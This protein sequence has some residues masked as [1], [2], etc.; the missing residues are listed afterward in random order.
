M[1]VP[2][3]HNTARRI[4]TAERR[5]RLG[6]RHWLAEPAGD[7]VQAARGILAYH[8][9]DPASVHIAAAVRTGLGGA[10]VDALER[11]LYD[12]RTLV[13]MLGMRRTM[14]V[15]PTELMPVIQ[16]ACADAIAV[17]ERRKTLQIFGEAGIV[18]DIEPW[19]A[20]VEADTLKAL[21]R[22]GA[23]TAA[24]LGADVPWLREQITI[25]K[26]KPYE[27]KLGVSSKVLFL[28]AT[29][30]RLVRGRPN[31]SWI[32]SQYRWAP[33]ETW[34][35]EVVPVPTE[36]ARAELLRHWLAAFG[37]GTVADLKW[38]TGW[39]L[40]DVRKTVAGMEVVDVE[41]DGEPGLVLAE[42][43]DPVDDPDPW[44]ALL[45]ALD[46]TPMGWYGRDFYL[47]ADCR[48]A[49]FDRNGNVGPSVWCDGR[50]VGGWAQRGDGTV[51]YRVLERVDNRAA[52]RI[53]VLAEQL[54]E[55]FGSV[56]PTP[57][58]RTPL[59]KELAAE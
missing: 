54:T 3:R 26:G 51:R 4:T 35:P 10:G 9:T 41:L 32:S 19:W 56:R 27:G 40:G 33:V 5:A 46:A 24:E 8:A 28:L 52:K 15:P 2:S 48:A 47:S 55:W 39:T 42:D 37:P 7:P 14:F 49:L 13:R 6:R 25:A 44:V 31:G 34:L 18:P 53:E 43:V 21:A 16:A 36:T 29:E 59:E 22:R 58:F 20:Q 12:D 30:G 50:I 17:R 45:P 11:A 38:W 57:R 1:T 23:A